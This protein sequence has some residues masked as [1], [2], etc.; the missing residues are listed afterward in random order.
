MPPA[1]AIPAAVS[2]LVAGGSMINQNV[3]NKATLKN[4]ENQQAAAVA[5]AQQATKNAQGQIAA[6]NQANPAPKPVVTAPPP[7]GPK[8]TAAPPAVTAPGVPTPPA[9]ANA[10]KAA[11]PSGPANP[12]VTAIVRSAMQQAQSPA[13]GANPVANAGTNALVSQILARAA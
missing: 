6:W 13:A 5:N 12:L 4:N 9:A 7:A 10:Q 2:L 11:T 8:M 1:V 3:Q